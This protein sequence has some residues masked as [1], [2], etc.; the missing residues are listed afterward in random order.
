MDTCACVQGIDAMLGAMGTRVVLVAMALPLAGCGSCSDRDRPAPDAGASVGT[1]APSAP[2]GAPDAAPTGAARRAAA[3]LAAPRGC[4]APDPD[5]W[6]V[7]EQGSKSVLHRLDASA[8]KLTSIGEIPC[9]PRHVAI[10]R[11]GVL[12]GL[13]TTGRL[14]QVSRKDAS[15]TPTKLRPGQHGFLRFYMAFVF[16]DA[17]ETLYASDE[18]V[19]GDDP[20]P[21]LGLAAIDTRTLS[22]GKLG[23][24]D[25]PDPENDEPCALAGTGD[26]RL[27]AACTGAELWRVGK[28]E[29]GR[30]A[31]EPVV[32]GAAWMN[33]SRPRPIAFWGGAIL[34]FQPACDVDAHDTR[35]A[36][37]GARVVSYS[38]RDRSPTILSED[39]GVGVV[40]AT[41]STCAPL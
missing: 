5:V 33:P 15:C 25:N 13:T 14:F 19:E 26:G 11:G 31:L 17:K 35:C 38:L 22:V 6:V 2:V 36:E 16:D 37:K 10:D 8:V 39:L 27:F 32:V 4:S 1:A 20:A 12:W 24:F 41:S 40:A 7:S 28:V 3:E 18:H 9:A 29:R 34:S 30:V 23:K 21:S